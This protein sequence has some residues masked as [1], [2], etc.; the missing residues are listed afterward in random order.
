MEPSELWGIRMLPMLV[1][2]FGIWIV[3]DSSVYAGCLCVKAVFDN[4]LD[5]YCDGSGVQIPAQC[6]I[7]L[8]DQQKA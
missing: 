3:L 1:A 2:G 7:V 5:Y 6:R 8:S 4:N